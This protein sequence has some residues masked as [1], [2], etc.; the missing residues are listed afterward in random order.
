[1][2]SGN[3]VAV[4]SIGAGYNTFTGGVCSSAM[5]PTSTPNSSAVTTNSTTVEV[6]TSYEGVCTSLGISDSF[7][8][9]SLF[10]DRPATTPLL[11][12][13]TTSLAV[14]IRAVSSSPTSYAVAPSLAEG[15]QAP[16]TA[17][18]ANSFF[19]QY[20]DCYVSSLELGGVY[21]AVYV[22]YCQSLQE[23]QSLQSSLSGLNGPINESTSATLT[24]A[25]TNTATRWT[26]H[27]YVFGAGDSDLPPPQDAQALIAFAEAFPA[28]AA[29]ATPAVVSF[30]TTGY[31]Q[32][33]SFQ[34]LAT[35]TAFAPIITNRTTF[36]Q[37]IT[38][39]AVTLI[40]VQNQI[41]TI[42]NVYATYGGFDDPVLLAR[43]QA[44]DASIQLLKKWVDSIAQNPTSNLNN[45]ADVA[46]INTALAYGSPNLCCQTT[47]GPSLG[48]VG[49]IPFAD[50]DTNNV[51]SSPSSSSSPIP[52]VQLPLLVSIHLYGSSAIGAIQCQYVTK[53]PSQIHDFVHGS[54]QNAGGWGSILFLQNGEFIVAVH[55]ATANFITQLRFTTNYGQTITFPPGSGYGEPFQWSVPNGSTLIGFQGQA[56]WNLHQL[57]ARLISFEPATWTSLQTQ[58]PT[59][60]SAT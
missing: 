26:C 47:C 31:E 5:L 46:Q 14:V 24:S 16:T 37:N 19:Q 42:N 27:Q 25:L 23:Q 4:T 48:V 34:N 52:L 21:A 15:I 20:G 53:S 41:N 44:I 60:S 38:P 49:G 39:N 18:Q 9:V 36:T 11:D 7:S 3:Q 17:E 43:S 22:F 55:G 58:S 29:Q 45:A 12:M 1:M 50:I 28:S 6:C 33:P 2:M 8:V 35:E 40:G 32:L 56:G 13:T 10:R 59:T 30:T 51:A 57:T 54:L